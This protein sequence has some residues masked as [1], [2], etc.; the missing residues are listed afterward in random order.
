METELQAARLPEYQATMLIDRSQTEPDLRFSQ[1]SAM[2]KKYA[3]EV[4]VRVVDKA[5][6]FFGGYGYMTEDPLECLTPTYGEEP[7][8]FSGRSA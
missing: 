6:H 7:I 8:R 2:A 1:V 3:S 4:A 5:L